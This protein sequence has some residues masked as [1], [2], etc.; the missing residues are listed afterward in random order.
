MRLRLDVTASM[1]SLRHDFS[2]ESMLSLSSDS[3]AALHV[4]FM[5]NIR[6]CWTLYMTCSLPRMS[7]RAQSIDCADPEGLTARDFTDSGPS[8]NAVHKAWRG[9]SQINPFFEIHGSNFEGLVFTSEHCLF[10][11]R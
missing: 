9:C 5:T 11:N 10:N 4:A 6:V 8:N 3:S 7:L 2:S 1:V